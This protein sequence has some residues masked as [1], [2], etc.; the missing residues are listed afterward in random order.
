[1]KRLLASLSI[2]VLA[3]MA[4]PADAQQRDRRGEPPE[5]ARP[6]PPPG[7]PLQDRRADRERE[8][9]RGSDRLTPE[10]RRKLRED[11]NNHGREIYRD[12]DRRR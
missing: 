11:I 5:H 8:Q 4:A 2:A 7:K 9:E 1:L 6:M 12:K 3:F 10:E